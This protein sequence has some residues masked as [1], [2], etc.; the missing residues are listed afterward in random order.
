MKTKKIND[1]LDVLKSL[2]NK[3]TQI[4]EL[5]GECRLFSFEIS[6]I[7]E[8]VMEQNGIDKENEI[9]FSSIMEFSWGDMSRDKLNKIFIKH[10]Q[11]NQ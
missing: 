11:H 3:E 4:Q 9:V 5:F 1:L 7:A 6:A 8:I 2:T 10:Q